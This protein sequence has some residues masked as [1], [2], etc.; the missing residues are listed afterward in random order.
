M[1]FWEAMRE[2][3]TGKKV[4]IRGS[5][6]NTYLEKRDR[7]FY[8]GT[9]STLSSY[10]DDNWELYEEPVRLLSFA[11]IVQ[12]LREGKRFRRKDSNLIIFAYPDKDGTICIEKSNEAWIASLEDL[13]ANDWIE[14]K[15]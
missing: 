4:R 8:F 3:E 14:V 6:P 12:G 5:K 13:E 2:L 9:W 11:E 10:I 1:K 15:E 7:I